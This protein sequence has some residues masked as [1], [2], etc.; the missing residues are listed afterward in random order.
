MFSVVLGYL[1]FTGILLWLFK[2]FYLKKQQISTDVPKKEYVTVAPEKLFKLQK[3][4]SEKIIKNFIGSLDFQKAV[5]EHIPTGKLNEEGTNYVRFILASLEEKKNNYRKTTSYFL[6]AAAIFSI[7]FSVI[8]IYFGYILLNEDSVGFNKTLKE[9]QAESSELSNLYLTDLSNRESILQRTINQRTRQ[10]NESLLTDSL[11]INPIGAPRLTSLDSILQNMIIQANLIKDQLEQDTTKR[12]PKRSETHNDKIETVNEYIGAVTN[13]LSSYLERESKLDSLPVDLNRKLG[14]IAN[15]FNDLNEDTYLQEFIRR[16]AISFIVVTFFLAII[17]FCVNQYKTN[18]K[19]MIQSESDAL[20]VRKA[21][22]ALQNSEDIE[23]Q[24]IIYEA[25]LKHI[26]ID[27]K[28]EL[29]QNIDINKLMES[30]V[31]IVQKNK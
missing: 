20:L 27:S 9:I 18:Y 7:L 13:E 4:E 26:K 15:S 8:I 19:E 17:R 2:D 6:S 5:L 23:V 3:Q 21:Y 25:L 31:S 30:L 1:F 29:S 11:T 22:L 28:Q 24:K 12:T 16:T 14:Q 10:L